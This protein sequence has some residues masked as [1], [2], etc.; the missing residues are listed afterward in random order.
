[1]CGII[2][3]LSRPSQRR[4]PE[5]EEVLAPLD[6]A[7]AA[8]SLD[9]AAAAAR[10]CDDLLKGVPGVCALIGRYE[11]A[12]GIVARLDQLEARPPP[13]RTASSP[14]LRSIPTSTSA[15]PPS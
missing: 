4:A 7:V 5:P 11:L 14:T 12:V 8:G 3:I 9:H 1:M 2:G 15:S 13:R 6:Q 10:R